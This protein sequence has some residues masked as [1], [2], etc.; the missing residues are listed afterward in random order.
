MKMLRV[1]VLVGAALIS[2]QHVHGQDYSLGPDSQVQSGV[3]KGT[4]TKYELGSGKFFPG[5]PHSYAIYVPAQYDAAKP[6]P[7]M[8]F[9]D[10][11]AF[12]LDSVRVPVVFDNLIAS[13]ELPPLIGIFVNPGTLPAISEQ[14][15]NR[16]ERIFEYDSLSDRYSRFLLE[17][18][19]PEVGKKYNLS[20]N[21][22]DRALCGLST[23]AV[24]AF[25]AAWNRP[26]EFHRVLSFIGTYVAMKGA[27]A[28]PALI[29]KTEPKPIRIFLQDGKK[30]HIVDAEPYGT[31]FAGSWPINNEV[32]FEAFQSAGYDAKLVMGEGGHDLKQPAAIMPE[33]LRWLWRDYPAPIVTHEP[34]AMSQPGWDSRGKV[35]SVV[36]ADKPWEQ[37]GEV[38]GE[39]ATPTGDKDGNVFFA[40]AA[41]KRIYKADSNGRVN[42]F[43]EHSNG[44]T[45]LRV[46]PDG[47]LY[48][49]QADTQLIVSYG[50]D[51]NEKL[52]VRNVEASN[53]AV[54]AQSTVYFADAVHKTIGYIDA[55]G[56]MRTVYNRGEIA[57]PSGL[58]L[59]PDQAM[60]IVTDG[61]SRF[62][63]SFQIAGD[64][65][66]INGEP[67]Y[68][69]E[70][71][72][73][74]WKSGVQGVVEDAD[75][76]VYF[77]SPVG[78]QFCEANG[79][80]AGILNPPEHGDVTGL[81]FAGENLDWLY[82]AEGGKLFRRAVKVRGVAVDRPTKPP[83]A[84]L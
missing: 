42:V 41:T 3:P 82:V 77:A 55:Q 35:Y 46:G 10:G 37:I 52:V 27:D 43:K 73:A 39:V 79:R 44:A 28:L 65:S 17:E 19:I 22:D 26:D 38:Y 54:T 15:Q 30:D 25:M 53:I 36:S 60:L 6:A 61:E 78:I 75:G 76:Q 8:I 29:R 83:A 69:L 11:G 81:T 23:G 24:G 72:E 32:M 68:R 21:P 20:K 74:G 70:M 40:D 64:G 31:Y 48:A 2:G 58:A 84:P 13:H 49:F 51:R 59:S 34:S 67:F 12:L 18:L 1:A 14:S 66:L 50:S 9:L 4:V 56:R 71:P 45:A 16:V 62:S 80:V 63:W 7:F 5:T 57:T 47:R 33:A